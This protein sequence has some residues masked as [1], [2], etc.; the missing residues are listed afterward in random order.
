MD[1]FLF[2]LKKT[3]I[4]IDPYVRHAVVFAWKDLLWDME[5]H[6]GGSVIKNKATTW[7]TRIKNWI[8][9]SDDT[10]DGDD[11]ALPDDE[12]RRRELLGID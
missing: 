9:R 12:V 2:P 6:A 8:M 5:K 7:G 10:N 4:S 11:H 3:Q 1:G